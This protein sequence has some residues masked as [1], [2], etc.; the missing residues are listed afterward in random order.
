M[1]IAKEKRTILMRF[2][3]ARRGNSDCFWV[4]EFLFGMGIKKANLK[5]QIRH[6]C[7]A[8]NFY[9]VKSFDTVINVR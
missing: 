3:G 9:G 1:V 7:V 8:A 4:T 5:S 2:I 6:F